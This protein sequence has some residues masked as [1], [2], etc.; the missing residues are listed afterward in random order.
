[1]T[2]ADKPSHPAYVYKRDIARLAGVQRPVATTWTKRHPTTFPQPVGFDDQGDYYRLDQVISWLSNRV[3][4][5]RAR[6]EQEPEG[7]TYGQR[8]RDRA[9]AEYI[10]RTSAVPAEAEH[11]QQVLSMVLGQVGR[12]LRAGIVSEPQ[13]ILILLGVIFLRLRDHE[14]WSELRSS[15]G[16]APSTALL[17]EIGFRVDRVLLANGI[18]PGIRATTVQLVS[19]RAGDVRDLLDLC[20]NLGSRAFSR[21]IDRYAATSDLG[22]AEYFTPPSVAALMAA[23]VAGGAEVSGVIY[24]P[25]L[26][27]GELLH[28]AVR[29]CGPQADVRVRGSS[30]VAQTLKV[31]AMRMA[32]AGRPGEFRLDSTLPWNEQDEMGATPADIVLTNPPFNSRTT[33]IPG[34]PVHG[35]A[36]GDP[37]S[38]ND[39]FAWLQYVVAS[40]TD[41]GVAAVLMPAQAAVSA[42]HN[43]AAIRRAM[44]EQGAIRAVIALPAKM[45]PNTD[46]AASLWIVTRP[47]KD[48]DAVLLVDAQRM[49][50]SDGKRVTLPKAAA[51]AI[52]RR[53]DE[54]ATLRQGHIVLLAENGLAVNASAATIGAADFRLR[55]SDYLH[56]AAT[57]EAEPLLSE[58]EEALHEFGRLRRRTAPPAMLDLLSSRPRH[59]RSEP[60]P[61]AAP[62]EVRIAEICDIQPGPSPDLMPKSA[63]DDEPSVAVVKRQHMRGFR[64]VVT[65]DDTISERDAERLSKYLAQPD[66]ILLV[67][68]GAMNQPPAIVEA[69]QKPL[70]LSNN[71]V[72]LR[73]HDPE[74]ADPIFL[75][76][77][78]SSPRILAE[79]ASRATGTAVP[80][81]SKAA[82][83]R[84]PIVLPPIS[85]QRRIGAV[86][87]AVDAQV[88]TFEALA[89][90]ATRAR[91]ALSSA[92]A[93]GVIELGDPTGPSETVEF[94][95]LHV[96]K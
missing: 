82:L 90:A 63:G 36:F 21:L 83:G 48:L 64:V 86:I 51:A 65:G 14:S 44:V 17:Q 53:Y 40:L 29:L 61:P 92:L 3:V 70:L 19:G 27:G 11:I 4:P 59:A 6:S 88:A 91:K 76:G 69:D 62:R 81:L 30:A 80:S 74:V 72:R 23:L 67:R 39:N 1:M 78:L 47:R 71:L 56:R 25:H 57:A 54:R 42:D 55:P 77:Y 87:G 12:R 18:A 26:R 79:V 31:A 95:G 35:W 58:V 13:F 38:Y 43:E 2:D 73:I 8:V 33:R 10:E 9:A 89:E 20:D 24:D 52:Q 22:S 5:E 85:E 16:R 60:D 37:P 41:N 84:Q 49:G 32:V 96:L 50:E 45:F 46:V 75:L 28:A 15:A 93:A 66:D 94:E 68:S 34:K 7:I